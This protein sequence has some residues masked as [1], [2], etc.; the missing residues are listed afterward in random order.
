MIAMNEPEM[1]NEERHESVSAF[2]AM[3]LRRTSAA[4]LEHADQFDMTHWMSAPNV[5]DYSGAMIAR[6]AL[7]YRDHCGTAFCLAGWIVLTAPPHG[8][9]PYKDSSIPTAA[10]EIANLTHNQS[11]RLFHTINW[12]LSFSQDYHDAETRLAK[13]RVLA[14][15]VEHF[16]RTG[17]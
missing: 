17:E 2:Q 14:R 8:V 5:E 7:R 11:N 4:I 16:I 15:R 1:I 13:A 3:A 9:R 10:R 6:E 12:P